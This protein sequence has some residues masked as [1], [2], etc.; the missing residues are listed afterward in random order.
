MTDDVQDQEMEALLDRV[1]RWCQPRHPGWDTLLKRLGPQQAGEAGLEEERPSRRAE[2]GQSKPSD[3]RTALRRWLALAAGLLV[4]VTMLGLAIV[5]MLNPGGTTAV[6]GDLPVEVHRR[7]IE[8]TIFNAAENDEPTLYTPLA[9]LQGGSGDGDSAAQVQRRI[10]RGQALAEFQNPQE[11]LASGRYR[12]GNLG[13]GLVKDQGMGLVKDQRMVLHL[14]AGD[15]VVK[16]TDV[17]ATIDPTSV[18]LTSESDPAGIQAGIQVVEQNF[19]YDLAS[20][21]ALLKRSLDRRVTCIGKEDKELLEGFLVSYD[22]AALSLADAP[23][24]PD[25]KAPRPKVQSV[26][27]QQLKAIRIDEMPKDL[28]TRP[29]LVWKLRAAKR[30]DHLATLTYLCGNVV[31]QADYVAAI[32]KTGPDGRDTLDLTGWVTIDNRSGTT[33]DRAG[34]KLIAGD[35]HRVRDPWALPERSEEEPPIYGFFMGYATGGYVGAKEFTTKDFFEYKLYTLSQPS[36]VADNQIKQLSLLRAAGVQGQR[37][38]LFDPARHATELTVE[39]V[40]KNEKSNGLGLPLPKGRV[41]FVG[42]DA[43]GESHFLGRDQIDHTPKDEELVLK[44]GRAF[45]AAGEHR[46]VR[47]EVPHPNRRIETHEIRVR[48]HKDA[49]IRVRAVARLQPSLNWQITKTT[50]E[51]A[52]HDFQTLHFDFPLKANA[53]KRVEYTVDYRW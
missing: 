12:P 31:W 44:L 9:V 34:L 36:T 43:D 22:S 38:F 29:T 19:E 3:R 52:K 15:N 40:V 51:Y 20:G 24:S 30:G 8:V 18:R 48:N 6:A 50:D 1:G 11:A 49:G 5:L 42:R 21:D 27:R 2:T 4:A 37:R 26:T 33:Y 41:T 32:E 13:M 16:F 35:V 25:P 14:K 28:H 45:D 39:L 7:G 17:A 10:T 23:P 46:H 53:E 47:T